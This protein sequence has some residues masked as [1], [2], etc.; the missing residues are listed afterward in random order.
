MLGLT[1]ILLVGTFWVTGRCFS[2]DSIFKS[3]EYVE[4]C[5]LRTYKMRSALCIHAPCEANDCS[6]IEKIA[7]ANV[8]VYVEP[9]THLPNWLHFLFAQV[10]AE[11]RVPTVLQSEVLFSLNNHKIE[12]LDYVGVSRRLGQSQSKESLQAKFS[13]SSG[14]FAVVMESV[15]DL[16][17]DMADALFHQV[18][19]LAL[20][21]KPNGI[22]VQ[23]GRHRSYG[24]IG[25]LHC[26]I[27]SFFS[28]VKALF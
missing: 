1:L 2:S 23:V 19:T 6:S 10:P 4:R 17:I 26:S 20:W 14:R 24:G 28:R 27:G 16:W 7:V 11:H 5:L 9:L 3:S 12:R 21:L 8:A 25:I 18:S 13:D 15:V 22:D